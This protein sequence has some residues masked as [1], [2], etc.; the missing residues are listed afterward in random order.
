M[1]RVSDRAAF[2][3]AVSKAGALPFLA[4]S[5]LARARGQAPP[6]RDRRARSAA[7]P[8]ASASSASS[9]RNLRDEQ[10]ALLRQVRPTV[11]LI[12]GG[13][14]SHARP[15]EDAGIATYLHVPSP[16][17]LDLFLKD[18]ARRFVFEGRECGG[19]VG[20]RS[21]FVLWESAD[22][23]PPRRRRGVRESRVLFAGGIHDARSA[24]M[25]AA[26]AAPL[27]ARG[28]KVGVLMGTAY[29]FTEEAVASGRHRPRV[30]GRS[31]PLRRAR[32][33]SRPRR[34]TPPA[35]P[36][37]RTRARSREKQARLEKEG[38]TR[39]EMWEALEQLNLGRLRIAAKGLTREER[40]RIVGVGEE[41][42]RQDGMFMIGQVARA[43]RRADARWLELHKRR[44]RGLALAARGSS[45]PPTRRPRQGPRRSTSPSWASP[46]IFPDAP[47][48]EAF[49]R[50][51][52]LGKNAIREVPRERWNPEQ[53][54]DPDGAGEK[55]PSKW[56][57]FLPEA[58][59][60]RRAT[61]SRRVRC[62]PSIRCS[63]SALDVARRALDDAGY[64]GVP[65]A[66]PK[67]GPHQERGARS[68]ASERASS[69]ARRR[70]RSSRTA[71]AS[72]RLYPQYLG[73]I[74]EVLDAQLPRLT[75]DSFPGVLSN[76]IAGR[77][78]NRLDLG[79]VNYTVD[80]ACASSLAAI[81]LAVQGARG[82]HQRHGHRR[83][84][85]P[86][87]QHQRLPP[88]RQRAR[89][90]PARP[91]PH[92]R[93]HADG[94]VLGEGIAAWSRS[95]L[96]TRRET[97][98]G[99][100]RSSRRSA[101]RATARASASPRRAKRARCAPSR[102]PTEQA[103]VSPAEVGLVEAHG[104]GTVVGDRTELATLT[105]F[106]GA[107]GAAP[108]AS[109]LG[110]V[111]SKSATPSAR[112]ASRGSSRRRCRWSGAS[113]LRP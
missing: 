33:S 18:G 97:A 11:A 43:P 6:R 86:P 101:A 109:T 57:G 55:T 73:A 74:P 65:A 32:C 81:D 91:V 14:P 49:W 84:R 3:D 104:T 12:A 90:L 38:K 20:P 70:A 2:A 51:I 76:V 35:A 37:R 52:V 1:T 60:D 82:G 7:A 80:A 47:D 107:A 34:A 29:L 36:R 71:T 4:L 54:Y 28:A 89:A 23:A 98:I 77:I 92:L 9:R 16:G 108:L 48:K 95:G 30:P 68:I 19:H 45:H 87:Q 5:L 106:F 46:C 25:V 44:L 50:N 56:G 113:S 103:G 66:S 53:Y 40:R 75:E 102:G 94:I 72:A 69:S 59:F 31:H 88:L 83:R 26:L 17:L 22:R 10:L 96:P 42:Q 78:A 39:Q 13:R 62:R 58:L 85:R 27:A 105:E 110:S 21:S 64:D 79:G 99:S 41:A 112:R 100:T 8:G 15:L 67:S 61:A 63:S 93:R 24:A 111:K